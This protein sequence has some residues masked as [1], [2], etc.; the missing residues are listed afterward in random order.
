MRTVGLLGSVSGATHATRGSRLWL[1]SAIKRCCAKG[2]LLWPE[3]FE[4]GELSTVSQ[5]LSCSSSD[6]LQEDE[7]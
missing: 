3:A 6:M 2:L 4:A 1:P 7:Q 5:Q